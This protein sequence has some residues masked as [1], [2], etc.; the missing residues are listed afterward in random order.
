MARR[1]KRITTDDVNRIVA[2]LD[3][4]R[5]RLTWPLLVA[6]IAKRTGER[7]TRQAL[8]R[9]PRIQNAFSLRKRE[10][11]PGDE[12][13]RT[14]TAQLRGRIREEAFRA[15]RLVQ[16]NDILYENLLVAFANAYMGGLREDQIV[17]GEAGGASNEPPLSALEVRLER[18]GQLL[19]RLEAN[20]RRCTERER[21]RAALEAHLKAVVANVKK[22]GVTEEKLFRP[23]PSIN[24]AG[25][26]RVAGAPVLSPAG[27]GRG[28]R[29]AHATRAL[30]SKRSAP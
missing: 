10:G 16:E 5:A 8:H 18:G 27:R 28:D 9:H 14:T 2:L 23:L 25:R 7:Y 22:W 21:L 15:Q 1:A 24:R 17:P 29:A 20:R 26:R 6:A 30:D 12:P 4:W 19:R 13:R 3:T 11:A